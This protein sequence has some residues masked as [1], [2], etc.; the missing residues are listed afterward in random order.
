MPI[1]KVLSKNGKIVERPP[2][3]FNCD[4]LAAWCADTPEA[5]IKKLFDSNACMRNGGRLINHETNASAFESWARGHSSFGQAPLYTLRLCAFVLW[6]CSNDEIAKGVRMEP[7][8]ARAMQHVRDAVAAKQ[9]TN[10]MQTVTR[11]TYAAEKKVLMVAG[12]VMYLLYCL[13]S[14]GFI[15]VVASALVNDY[16]ADGSYARGWG[17][18]G[19]EDHEWDVI[20]KWPQVYIVLPALKAFTRMLSS[21]KMLDL[22]QVRLLMRY[23]L[24][25]T[26]ASTVNAD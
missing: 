3:S 15:G 25:K 19:H 16:D 8:V 23:H 17:G 18:G 20:R 11:G 5:L 4:F 12:A 13:G 7:A 14:E 9:P 26:G 22:W 1:L 24:S 21:F 2:V 6:R 10:I